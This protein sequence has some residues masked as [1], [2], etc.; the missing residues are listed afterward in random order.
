M[1]RFVPWIVIPIVIGCTVSAADRPV[2]LNP[3]DG[4][5]IGAKG[6]PSCRPEQPCYRIEAEGRVPPG[7]HPFFLVEPMSVSPRMWVQPRIHGVA[8][9]GSVTGTVY[10]GEEDL[11]AKEFY[12]IYLLACRDPEVFGSRTTVVRMPKG[13]AVSNAVKVYRFR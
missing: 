10:L 8:A 11:G 13:C 1:N 5:K 12:K 6:D 9:D 4:Q 2:I 3:V 7:V